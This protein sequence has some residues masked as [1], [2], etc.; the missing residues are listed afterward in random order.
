VI[1][2][3]ILYLLIALFFL[4]LCIDIFPIFRDWIGRIK[5]GKYED[6][7]IWADNIRK[8]AVKWLINTPKIKVT[9][10]TRLIIL[11]ILTGNYTKAAIQHWQQ[12][13]LLLGM[14]EYLKSNDDISLQKTI[15]TYL[16]T[17]FDSRGQWIK[18]PQ[19]ID[20]AILA[21]S[22]MKLDFIDIN[23]YKVAFDTV[24]EL[25]KEHKGEDGTIFYRHS[26]KKY[27]YVDTI[28]FICPFLVTYGLKYGKEECVELAIAQ[29]RNYEQY[30]IHKEH[31]IPVHA[32]HFEKNT[33]LGLYGWGRGLGWYALGLMDSWKELP[34]SNKYKTE[35][36]TYVI[37][38]AK[39]AINFQQ[40][41]GSWCWTV[42]RSES[43]SDSSTTAI[44]GWYLVNVA[45][46]SG[47][48][49]RY[50]RH[51]GKAF[52]YLMGVTRRNGAVDFSQGDTKDIGVYSNHFNLLPF[53]Q[54]FC[55]RLV[56]DFMKL[57]REKS[58][59]SKV[60]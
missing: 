12:A 20:V 22:V 25:I 6:M 26:T 24:W 32:Y 5:I 41:N 7:D 45:T 3:F 14:N 19:H 13:S 47:N 40:E 51:S 2:H 35:F 54:G 11:D 31:S 39:A 50:L 57:T 23:K 55:I 9:D 60:S 18:K 38:F 28:G 30:G 42:T 52:N 29:I 10:N 58:S 46:V 8:I 48:A 53:T 37:K 59:K 36:E 4:V 27:R 16:D 17:T 43:V 1:I 21:Y 33:P 49:E 56:N 15:L 34:V 44:L